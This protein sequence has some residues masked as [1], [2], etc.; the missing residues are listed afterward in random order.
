MRVIHERS[1]A[2]IR[3]RFYAYLIPGI[4]MVMAI[5]FGSLADGIIIGNFVGEAAL[6]AS[7]LALPVVY[8]SQA[9]AILIAVGASIVVANLLGKRKIDDASRV[10]KLSMLVGFL[11]CMLFVPVGI[12]AAEPISRFLAGDGF[13]DL[14]PLITDYS[15]AFLIQSPIIAVSFIFAYCLASD[16]SPNLS[17]AFFIIGNLAHAGLELL[18]CFLAKSVPFFGDHVLLWAALA[19]G[20]GLLIGFVVLIPYIRSKNRLLKFKRGFAGVLPNFRTV[21]TSGLTSGGSFLL[22]AVYSLFLNIAAVTYLTD[23]STL[24]VFAMMQN[25]VF[26]VDL[27]VTGV[28]QIVPNIVG[29]LYGEKDYFS[30]KA[31]AK[32]ALFISLL[33]AAALTAISEIYPDLF[34]YMFGVDIQAAMESLDA[35][36]IIRI[37][38]IS[39][40]IYTLNKFV[41]TYYPSILINMPG[42]VAQ[43]VR[44]GVVG[45][46]VLYFSIAASGAMGYCYG[47]IITEAS[48]LLLTVAFIV[49]MKAAHKYPEGGLW[50]L[51]NFKPNEFVEFSFPPVEKEIGNFSEELQ[52]YA[53]SMGLDDVAAA[54]VGLAGE[55]IIDNVIKYGSKNGWK[56][57]ASID[58]S[59]SKVEDTLILRVRD[60]GIAFD[61]TSSEVSSDELEFTGIEVLRKIAKAINYVRVLN[62]NNTFI[63]LAC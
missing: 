57:D 59:L 37:Y 62:T 40:L 36:L 2:L 9:P 11:F 15:M 47:T 16:N 18:F 28:M 29:A 53:S 58:V 61:P 44:N 24:A 43:I 51:P 39:F 19:L 63:E 32:R 17:A 48:A 25:F 4:I 6:S 1:V 52:R 14:V 27:F 12:F 54:K 35:R 46:P 7:S 55:E 60:D 56:K 8:I 42:I 34:F 3:K 20:L 21:L 23:G 10:F 50:L 26:V 30:V 49:I 38:C 45:I 13:Q 41:A 5:Q 22:L 31:I 33:I